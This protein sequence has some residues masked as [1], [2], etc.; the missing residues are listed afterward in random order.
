MN[1]EIQIKLILFSILYGIYFGGMIDLNH[2]YLYSNRKIFKILFT[3]IFMLFNIVLYFLI[4]KRINQGILHY[5]SF[6]C[7]VFGFIIENIIVKK[8]LK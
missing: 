8:Y 3:F 2:K 5:Y 4:L 7:I 6:L 1:I